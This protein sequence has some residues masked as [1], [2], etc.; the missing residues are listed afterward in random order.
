MAL[1]FINIGKITPRVKPRKA[2]P[3]RRTY[4]IK[5]TLRGC[6]GADAIEHAF[7]I[8]AKALLV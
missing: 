6:I 7:S 1:W 8:R 2:K 3:K 4:A 5:L